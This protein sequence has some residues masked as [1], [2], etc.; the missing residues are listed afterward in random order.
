MGIILTKNMNKKKS[1]HTKWYTINYAELK[2]LLPSL[3]DIKPLK[4]NTRLLKMSSPCVQNEQIIYKETEITSENKT[5]SSE[6]IK[7]V[8]RGGKIKQVHDVEKDNKLINKTQNT[9]SNLAVELLEIWNQTIKK[10]KGRKRTHFNLPRKE[11]NIWWLLLS[12]DLS[13][14]S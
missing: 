13:Q 6:E 11:L 12:I 4:Q 10:S 8:R 3:S 5:I 7:V 1:D 2:E 9:K 14:I